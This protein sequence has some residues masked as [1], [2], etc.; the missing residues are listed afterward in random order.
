MTSVYYYGPLERPGHHF[1]YENGMSLSHD[2][3]ALI[4]W[5]EW[6][7]DGKL[8]PGCWCDRGHWEHG[9]ENEGEALLHQKD[10]WTLISF[11]DRTI[12]H[13]FACNSS[14]IAKGIFTFEQMVELAKVR[15]AE[16]WNKMKFE[17]RLSSE[18]RKL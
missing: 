7:I 15:F 13:R 2:E 18:S 17:V 14:Y 11:W 10:G 16:R 6:E 1:F 9:Q 8:Q 4:P 5:K 12:D 3:R